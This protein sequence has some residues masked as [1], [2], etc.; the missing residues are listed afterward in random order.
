MATK[1]Q[2][3]KRIMFMN[4]R[5]TLK[6]NPRKGICLNCNRTVESGDI[7]FTVLHHTSYDFNNPLANTVELCVMCHRI[8][9]PKIHE[10]IS[11]K[12]NPCTICGIKWTRSKNQICRDC[13]SIK[14]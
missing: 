10:Y 1:I 11:A 3:Q 5:I 2:N 13:W 6:E 12:Y 14:K 7:K 9:H 4:K 8:I